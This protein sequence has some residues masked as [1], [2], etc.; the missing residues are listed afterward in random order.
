MGVDVEVAVSLKRAHSSVPISSGRQSSRV[1]G[2]ALKLAHEKNIFPNVIPLISA[3][4][5]GFGR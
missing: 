2:Q 4:T 5:T 1:C 3:G